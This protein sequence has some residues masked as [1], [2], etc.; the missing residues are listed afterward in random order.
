MI[1]LDVISMSRAVDMAVVSFV[2]LVA[3]DG[4]VDGDTT[5]PLLRRLVN[6]LVRFERG[7]LLS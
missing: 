5:S 1:Y 3:D 4:G 6:I 2:S 7:F